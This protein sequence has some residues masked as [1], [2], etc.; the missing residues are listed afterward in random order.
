MCL[1]IYV[2]DL[3]FWDGC[4]FNFTIRSG[5]IRKS[6][7]ITLKATPVFLGKGREVQMDHVANSAKWPNQRS[8]AYL[9]APSSKAETGLSISERVWWPKKKKVIWKLNPLNMAEKH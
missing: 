5:R 2:M 3:E 6:L 4:V 9:K 7:L 8:V 1:L